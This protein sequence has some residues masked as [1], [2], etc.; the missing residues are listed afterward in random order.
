MRN[1]RCQGRS[2]IQRGKS[3]MAGPCTEVSPSPKAMPPVT[4]VVSTRWRDTYDHTGGLHD[5]PS[6]YGCLCRLPLPNAGL[7]LVVTSPCP[8]ITGDIKHRSTPCVLPSY[9]ATSPDV[10]GHSRGLNGGVISPCDKRQIS[11]PG[12]S[13]SPVTAYQSALIGP[14]TKQP[15]VVGITTAC[16]RKNRQISTDG[17]TLTVVWIVVP[18]SSPVCSV[19]IRSGRPTHVW[20]RRTDDIILSHLTPAAVSG[21]GDAP[22][23]D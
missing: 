17:S 1:A 2:S 10:I 5:V 19:M 14:D 11:W 7:G 16:L 20:G 21:V 6:G 8:P 18:T 12:T 22:T 23:P 9:A 15:P 4:N 3:I 13:L